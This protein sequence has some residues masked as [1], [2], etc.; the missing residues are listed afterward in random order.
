MYVCF[1]YVGAQSQKSRE[2]HAWPQAGLPDSD[3]ALNG[4]VVWAEHI[5]MLESSLAII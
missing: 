3:N 5:C 2:L 4:K 1:D